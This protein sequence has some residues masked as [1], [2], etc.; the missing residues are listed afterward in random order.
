[1]AFDLTGTVGRDPEVTYVASGSAL[2][3][4]SLLYNAGTKEKPKNLWVKCVSWKDTA[5]IIY[6]EIRKGD[7]I[8]VSG[9]VADVETWVDKDGKTPRAALVFTVFEISKFIKEEGFRDIKS[10]PPAKQTDPK[11]TVDEDIPF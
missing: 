11:S 1:M 2:C 5:E 6:K 10:T 7:L 9:K 3:K 4:F 8:G